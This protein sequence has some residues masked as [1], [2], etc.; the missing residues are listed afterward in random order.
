M[1]IRAIHE[2]ARSLS[3]RLRKPGGETTKS[4][5]LAK[6]QGRYGPI[7][8]EVRLELLDRVLAIQDEVNEAAI[9]QGR[10]QISLINAAEELFIRKCIGDE[11]WPQG[12][13]GDE[14][15]G[16]EWIDEPLNDGSLQ[17]LLFNALEAG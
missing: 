14:P 3:N 1:G 9:A 17:P 5:K 4:G 2:T 15:G 7:K 8:L 12:W 10:P 11:V 16:D 6:K 13:S